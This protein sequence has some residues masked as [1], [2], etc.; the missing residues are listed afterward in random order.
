MSVGISGEIARWERLLVGQ[1]VGSGV[2]EE[3]DAEDP[4]TF[5][6]LLAY[7]PGENLLNE[8][9]LRR[10]PGTLLGYG[11]EFW[12]GACRPQSHQL[13]RF[14]NSKACGNLGPGIGD[15]G[16]TAESKTASK[17]ASGPCHLCGEVVEPTGFEPATPT[18]P[19]WCSTN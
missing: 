19:L 7:R 2:P 4:V 10:H 5:K 3:G 16:R 8:L 12:P 15:L 1:P 14:R 11:I 18:M 6:D 13:T 9:P 17:K